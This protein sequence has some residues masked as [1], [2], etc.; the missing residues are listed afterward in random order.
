MRALS[1]ALGVLDIIL[2]FFVI[3]ELFGSF[4]PSPD[5][6]WP[7]Q[8]NRI[9]ALGAA[10]VAVNLTM[11]KY[12][13]E[14]RM[15]PL[16]LVLILL[17]IWSFFRLLRHGHPEEYG[18]VAILTALALAANFTAGLVFAAEGLWLLPSLLGRGRIWPMPIRHPW[19]IVAALAAG[20][21]VLVIPLISQSARL[22]DLASQGAFVC[23]HPPTWSTAG[24]LLWDASGRSAFFAMAPL[25]VWGAVRGWKRAPSAISFTVLWLVAPVGLAA[26]ISYALT[27]VLIE[28]YVLSSFLP[29]FILVAAGIS[30]LPRPVATLGAAALV[31]ALAFGDV[32]RFDRSRTDFQWGV[33]WREAAALAGSTGAKVG[34]EPGLSIFVVRYYLRELGLDQVRF[35]A[36][37]AADV[38]VVADQIS[39]CQPEGAALLFAKYPKTLARLHG[40]T[41]IAR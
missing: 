31:L 12:S 9:A 32:L 36:G 13:R 6:N 33:Q 39:V 35:V 25:A 19:R 29:F 34:V 15:Y 26:V 24:A 20:F 2:S 3:R 8:V 1:V 40:V 30:E 27:P 7:E 41:V 17:Q 28:R 37:G 10:L 22:S 11:I 16:L 5:P 4:P 21:V 18:N 23:I 38:L 14:A